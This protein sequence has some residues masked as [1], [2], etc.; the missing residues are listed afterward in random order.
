MNK[1]IFNSWNNT[2]ELSGTNL[3]IKGY[4]RAGE[5]SCF[6]IPALSLMFDAGLRTTNTPN[7]IF[8]TH[9]HSDHIFDLP[10]ILSGLFKKTNVYSPIDK[11]QMHNF[12][13]SSFM[14]LNNGK[15]KIPPYQINKVNPNQ[16]IYFEENKRKYQM[17]IFKCYH[18][19]PTVGY[20]LSEIKKKLKKILL[21]QQ[22]L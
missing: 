6:Q 21:S 10:I 2:Y 20:G 5:R 13:N 1:D 9:C 14:L 8:I 15:N 3:T 7:N 4:S 16:I 18:R 22:L 12:I 17:E 11:Q 19:V